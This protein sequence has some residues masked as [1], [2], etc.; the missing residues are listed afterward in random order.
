V[1]AGQGDLP[2]AIA[3]MQLLVDFENAT[4][5]GNAVQHAAQVEELRKKI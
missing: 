3:S 4:G 5:Q 1:Y 2:R